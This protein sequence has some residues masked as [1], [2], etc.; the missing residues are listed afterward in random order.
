MV[1]EG[2]EFAALYRAAR[3]RKGGADE[4]LL[5]R[6]Q[7]ELGA[8]IRKRLGRSSRQA[9]EDIR[10][11]AMI[12]VLGR[13]AVYPPDLTERAFRS[14][15]FQTAKRRVG[16]WVRRK[17]EGYADSVLSCGEI[18]APC[19]HMGPA[20]E[21]GVRDEY[22]RMRELISGLRAIHA[23]VLRCVVLDRLSLQETAY[24]LGLTED[25]TRKR[26]R[27]AGAELSR[28][29]GEEPPEILSAP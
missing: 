18:D 15:L 6:Y 27:R 24:L 19:A 11:E 26:L 22:R 5:R 28:L 8:F 9:W 25:A 21:A 4:E 29:L 17:R 23:G 20:T 13:L 10:Q 3:V 16:I 14:Y 12:E 2:D 1:R 7:R